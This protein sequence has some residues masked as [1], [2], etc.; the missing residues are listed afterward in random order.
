LLQEVAQEC[1]VTA[2]PTFQAYFKGEKVDEMRG[3]DP[4]KLKAMV[5][6]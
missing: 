6:G 3:A 1:G 5:E 2:M 4:S